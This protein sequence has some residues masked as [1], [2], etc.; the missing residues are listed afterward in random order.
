MRHHAPR[1]R[2]N[3][4][5]Q[6]KT[7]AS[8]NSPANNNARR[9]RANRVSN[10]SSRNANRASRNSPPLHVRSKR[11]PTARNAPKAAH[12]S[13]NNDP[14]R[15]IRTTANHNSA[16]SSNRKRP[17]SARP[18]FPAKDCP[19]LKAS[20]GNFHPGPTTA[21]SATASSKRNNARHNSSSK[22]RS[23]LCR[24]ANNG[25][26]QTSSARSSNNIPNKDTTSTHSTATV[27]RSSKIRNSS[28]ERHPRLKRNKPLLT[29]HNSNKGR[30]NIPANSAN[31]SSASRSNSRASSSNAPRR[32]RRWNSTA[33]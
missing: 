14:N 23:S 1:C 26:M 12:R 24:P 25:H 17:S 11:P 13:S 3:S 19:T 27:A 33:S 32:R 10:P 4:A 31:K 7:A 6:P 22:I 18:V 28:Q 20:N 21:R 15:S 29:H 30:N 2:N 8:R 5:P 16:H 9:N